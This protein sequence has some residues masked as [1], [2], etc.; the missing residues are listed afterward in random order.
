[1]DDWLDALVSLSARGYRR[2]KNGK[3]EAFCSD[4]SKS[5]YLGTYAT[6]SQAEKAVLDYRIGRLI[7]RLGEYGLDVNDGAVFENEYIAFE[8]GMIFNLAGE[9]IAGGTNRDGYVYGIL[10]RKTVAFHRVIA[11]IFCERELGKDFVNHIDGNK[12]NNAA[13]NLEWVTR[14]ENTIHSYRHRLQN[15]VA[16]SPLYSDEEKE[17]MIE[18]RN[19]PYFMVA[20]ELGRNPE[21][22]RKYL[23]RYRKE[24]GDAE[25]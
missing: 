11:S 7:N 4:H 20:A 13:S 22:V 8:N 18:H 17:Y 23:Y 6:I 12:T 10:G 14:S 9:R 1:M 2:T 19:E 21:T 15:N 3:Y 5:V 16:G 24:F 25:D